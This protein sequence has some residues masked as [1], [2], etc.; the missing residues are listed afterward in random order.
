MSSL[1]SPCI[2]IVL[3]EHRFNFF[4]LVFFIQP[5]LSEHLLF[6]YESHSGL[7]VFAFE[8]QLAS[9]FVK[10]NNNVIAAGQ[11]LAIAA[12]SRLPFFWLF[13]RIQTVLFTSNDALCGDFIHFLCVWNFHV[14]PSMQPTL[15][16]LWSTWSYGQ[17]RAH[18]YTDSFTAAWDWTPEVRCANHTHLTSRL[19]RY[20][21]QM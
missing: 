6:L 12:C 20:V 13:S 16:K 15:V 11:H 1:L 9:V 8:L 3:L 2:N 14:V 4:Y 17:V 18:P 5:F 19:S 10:S 21:K 7:K